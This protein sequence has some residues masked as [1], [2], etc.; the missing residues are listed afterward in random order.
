MYVV[1]NSDGSVRSRICIRIQAAKTFSIAPGQ[2]GEQREV[3]SHG[4]RRSET[5]AMYQYAPPPA[6]MFM[7]RMASAAS[8][9]DSR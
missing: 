9:S 8:R 3:M 7:S 4:D 5:S 2:H 1:G 6:V